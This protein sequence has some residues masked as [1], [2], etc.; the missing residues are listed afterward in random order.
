[1]IEA[2]ANISVEKKTVK[3]LSV[4][5]EAM[6]VSIYSLNEGLQEHRSLSCIGEEVW[7]SP[8]AGMAFVLAVDLCREE[9][10]W[11]LYL[12]I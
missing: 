1:L 3:S 12:Y 9:D 11:F 10:V 4:L 7:P 5:P 6:D 2:S 8:V